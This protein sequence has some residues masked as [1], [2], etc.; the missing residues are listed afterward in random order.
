MKLERK[1]GSGWNS[2]AEVL[3]PPYSLNQR[4]SLGVLRSTK[5]GI[6]CHLHGPNLR[7]EATGVAG[8]KTRPTDAAYI[9]HEFKSSVPRRWGAITSS[10]IKASST[11]AKAT[12]TLS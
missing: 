8:Y 1:T 5:G 9:M 4:A 11:R 12:K 7:E 6:G 3:E 10:V 2:L